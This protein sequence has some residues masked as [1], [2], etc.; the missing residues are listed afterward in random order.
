MSAWRD[1]RNEASLRRLQRALPEVFPAP[2][3]AHALSRPFI[4]PT[5]R[6]A[7]ESYWRAHSVRADRLA[8][9]LAKAGGA[10]DGWSWRL[11]AET[12]RGGAVATFRMPPAPFR[13]AAFAR[14]PGFCCVCGQPVFRF[15]WHRDLWQT[16]KPNRNASWHAACVVAWQ[17]WSAPSGYVRPLKRRQ[18][19][20]C[21]QSAKRLLKGAEVDHA[22]PLFRVWREHRDMPWP[23]LLGF[24]GL[25]NLQVIN[26]D[27]HAV[28][29]AVEAG[30][31][32][33]RVE[34]PAPFLMD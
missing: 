8:R 16:G 32:R 22:T 7:V 24:W 15:G 18:R 1:T 20:R 14:G 25:P 17:L 13:E 31:R 23:E 21:P 27:A 4:P 29:C 6:R 12:T 19:F 9:A 5:P 10:P 33:R 3:L 11:E 26:R 34:V 2:V 28:K 30:L